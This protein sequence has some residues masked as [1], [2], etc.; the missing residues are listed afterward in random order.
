VTIESNE[1]GTKTMFD[2]KYNS[3]HATKK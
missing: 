3:I 1:H 2:F